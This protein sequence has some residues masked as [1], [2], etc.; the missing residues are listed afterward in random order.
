MINSSF[1]SGKLTSTDDKLCAQSLI[2]LRPLAPS[3]TASVATSEQYSDLSCGSDTEVPF[4]KSIRGSQADL[5]MDEISTDSSD[6]FH[7]QSGHEPDYSTSAESCGT[8]SD[9]EDETQKPILSRP[10]VHPIKSMLAYRA[11]VLADVTEPPQFRY[12]AESLSDV[13][14]QKNLKMGNSTSSSSV[15]VEE[16]FVKFIRSSLNDLTVGKLDIVYEKLVNRGI[17]T[18]A[19]FA[20]AIEEIFETARTHHHFI[21]ICVEM[22]SRFQHDQRISAAV[23]AVG[24]PQSFR[25]VLLDKCWPAFHQMLLISAELLSSGRTATKHQSIGNVRLLGELI[26]R[27]LVSPRLFI[28]SVE[29][30]LNRS[31]HCVDLLEPLAALLLTAGKQFRLRSEWVHMSRFMAV[32]ERVQILS[33]SA[34]IPKHLRLLLC[35]VTAA[36]TNLKTHNVEVKPTQRDAT[37]A[38]APK[39]NNRTS[40]LSLAKSALLAPD[41]SG[42]NQVSLPLKKTLRAVAVSPNN[43]AEVT[44]PSASSTASA[45]TTSSEPKSEPL[46]SIRPVFDPKVFRREL[47][48]ILRDLCSNLDVAAAVDRIH[49][50]K[51]PVAHQQ[52]EFVDI[53]TRASEV[54]SAPARKATFSLAVALAEEGFGIFDSSV[55]LAGVR[56]FFRDVYSDL[57]CEVPRLKVIMR[58][59]L[60]PTLRTVFSADALSGILPK[61]FNC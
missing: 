51:V 47:S 28:E 37:H 11:V 19:H 59:E 15:A 7:M 27:E 39:S 44:T 33:Q 35:D 13:S 61:E 54:A 4:V 22:C 12:S 58:T 24:S 25:Q 26:V 16:K 29:S 38:P 34:A 53:L 49:S 46:V 9:V 18:P 17:K 14:N 57:C 32:L 48:K 60:V 21:G 40:M 45:S 43:L 2:S 8:N 3:T 50:Q 6:E 23:G 10:C 5:K 30:M 55:C 52:H 1:M 42:N 36:M 56:V 20:V 41:R 31:E